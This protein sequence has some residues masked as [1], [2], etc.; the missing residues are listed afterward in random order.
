MEGEP[1]TLTSEY[2]HF[3]AASFA[4]WLGTKAADKSATL[5]VAVGRDPR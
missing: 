4:D 3:I 1:V 2:A 5:R